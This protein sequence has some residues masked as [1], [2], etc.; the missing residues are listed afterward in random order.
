MSNL[1]RIIKLSYPFEYI[2]DFYVI[3]CS[4][5]QQDLINNAAIKRHIRS[6][7]NQ[8]NIDEFI[9]FKSV[10]ELKIETDFNLIKL[11][12]FYMYYFDC[13]KVHKDFLCQVKQCQ[14]ISTH[15]RSM[16]GHL[17]KEH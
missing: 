13:L 14:F 9:L 6:H 10:N 5:C 4:K 12:E 2:I 17:N 1:S 11:S 16:R 15:E 7:H 3:I 8:D